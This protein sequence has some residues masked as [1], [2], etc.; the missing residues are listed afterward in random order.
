MAWDVHDTFFVAWNRAPHIMTQRGPAPG[1]EGSGKLEDWRTR[2]DRVFATSAD[3]YRD[4]FR[5]SPAPIILEDWSKTR[6]LIEEIRAAAPDSAE[7]HV[8]AHPELAER[9]VLSQDY[10]IANPAML[11]INR[12]STEEGYVDYLLAFEQRMVPPIARLIADLVEGHT[13]V[14]WP[15]M[16][17]LAYDGTDIVLRGRVFIPPDHVDTWS[18][19]ISTFEDITAEREDERELRQARDD[20]QRANATKA[21]FVANMSHEF[22]TPLNAIIGFAQVLRDEMFGPLGSPRYGSYVA[23][24]LE[25]GEHLLDLVNDILDLAKADAGRLELE[26]SVV[27]LDAL[28]EQSMR[29]VRDRAARE[30][31]AV[32]TH[33]DSSL[34]RLLGDNRRLRQLLLNLLTNAVKFT[35]HGGAITIRA[36]FSP[37]GG[38]EI[39]ITDTGIGM[40]P[41]E[42]KVAL[43]PFGQIQRRR[44]GRLEGTGLGLPIARRI[45]EMHGGTVEIESNPGQGTTAR[46][47]LPA[48]RIAPDPS[49]P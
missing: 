45:A 3:L 2:L 7:A 11:E 26:E 20:A 47:L 13:D 22:R 39:A 25:S 34:P 38:I 6:V 30:R 21:E 8:I 15:E 36:G 48:S 31:I 41:E 9:F 43:E 24:I 46:L 4:L 40:T 33:L 29:F 32:T 1:P 23:D 27:D 5:L 12:A 16:E 19:A 37:A 49:A 35:P 14:I 18:L 17:C 28:V 44:H 42:I 10:I